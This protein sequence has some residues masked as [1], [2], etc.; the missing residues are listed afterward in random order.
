MEIYSQ[1]ER[2]GG[3]SLDGKLLRG[4]SVQT[5]LTAFLLKVGQNIRYH[6]ADGRGQG[7]PL[8]IQGDHIS[9]MGHSG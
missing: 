8:Y 9:R 6:L 5:D 1:R 3:A 7:A 2:L 4:D